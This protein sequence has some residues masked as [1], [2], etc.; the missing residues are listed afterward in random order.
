M[1]PLCAKYVIVRQV[2]ESLLLW[3]RYF[4]H[5]YRE[6][7]YIH[8]HHIRLMPNIRLPV[9]TKDSQLYATHRLDVLNENPACQV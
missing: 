6:R 7:L 9:L 3:M 5:K 8:K 2:D 1:A 4:D